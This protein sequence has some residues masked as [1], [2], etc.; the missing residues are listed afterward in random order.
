MLGDHDRKGMTAPV[1]ETLKA[2][3]GY[4]G[5]LRA[6][7]PSV[8]E[9]ARVSRA[10]TSS[11]L[12][13]AET[14]KVFPN[15][16][17]RHDYLLLLDQ[18]DAPRVAT[19]LHKRLWNAELGWFI[20]GGKGEKLE[21]SPFDRAAVGGERLAFEGAP[22]VEPPLAQNAEARKAVAF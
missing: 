18:R 22:V 5:A 10:S 8:D 17:G 7:I 16:G 9:L 3:G 13:H 15:S 20:V 11:E 14:G 19:V 4:E 1:A 21:R 12:S 2:G 6:F